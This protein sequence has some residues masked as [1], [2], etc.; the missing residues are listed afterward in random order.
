MKILFL[1]M[2]I[3]AFLILISRKYTHLLFF[4]FLNILVTS[5][6][7]FFLKLNFFGLVVLLLYLG[8]ILVIFVFLLPLLRIKE[9]IKERKFKV[10]LYLLLTYLLIFLSLNLSSL[11]EKNDAYFEVKK[12]SEIVIKDY[13]GFELVSILL[14]VAIVGS[15]ILIKDEH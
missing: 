14:L 6:L 13:L 1:L 7:Y 5:I 9:E 10:I 3:T 2:P 8:S 15:Y 4:F 12:F 11:F